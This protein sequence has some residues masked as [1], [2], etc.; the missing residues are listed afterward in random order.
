MG[1]E[2]RTNLKRLL[3]VSRPEFIPA[4]MG[5]LIIGLAWGYETTQGFNINLLVM[6]ILSFLVI[7]VVSAIGA[8][9]NTL[10]DLELDTMDPRKKTL[11]QNLRE[12]GP[13]KVKLVIL[14]ELLLSGILVSLLVFMRGELIQLAIYFSALIL[15]QAY[16]AL[17][18]RLK[19]RSLLAMISLSLVL[20]VLPAIFIYLTFTRELSTLFIFFLIGQTLTVYSVIIPTET[21]DYFG[22]KAMSVNTM[23][24]WLGLSRATLLAL[25]LLAVGAT[26]SISAFLMTPTFIQNPLLMLAPLTM[27]GADLYIFRAYDK[28]YNLS[29]R[30]ES[31]EGDVKGIIGEEVVELSS[32]NPKWITITT[33]AIIFVN[34][35]YL[36]GKIF[37]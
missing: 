28:L 12:L 21:R 4:N 24:V 5:S 36:V 18:L 20:S 37:L 27:M 17:P 25:A 9:V 29:K 26:L 35:I 33:Q 6:T 10:S 14:F 22:D 31:E 7:T 3:V 13:Q 19:G 1:H 30:Q 32:K 16:S 15:T 23:T 2:I 11:T 34:L 8:Q